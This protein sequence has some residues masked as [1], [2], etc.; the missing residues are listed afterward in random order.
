MQFP[1]RLALAACSALLGGCALLGLGPPVSTIEGDVFLAD[2]GVRIPYAEICAFGIDTTCVR[3]DAQGHYRLRLTE[4]TIVLR[5]RAGQL[6]MAVSDTLRLQPPTRY[7]VSCGITD[8]LVIS[9]RP[10]PCQNP[11]I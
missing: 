6:P 4:Q 10:L 9:D 1:Q 8:R 2:Q 3:A 11:G 7:G 5:F